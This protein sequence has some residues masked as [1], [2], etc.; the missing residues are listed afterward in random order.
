MLGLIVLS[1]CENENPIYD[2][3]GGIALVGFEVPSN[4]SPAPVLEDSE[5][6]E[7]PVAVSVSNLSPVDRTYDITVN[8][9]DT[10]V[11][12]ENYTVPMTVT[13]PANQYTTNLIVEID[14]I[15]LTPDTQQIVLELA[16]RDE[17]NVLNGDIYTLS[18]FRSCPIPADYAVGDYVLEDLG[19]IGPA[20]G[21]VNITE[22]TYTLEVG[23]NQAQRVFSAQLLPLFNGPTREIAVEF[24]CGNVL[25]L[26]GVVDSG[27]T[28]GDYTPIQNTGIT[29][30]LADD[31]S[32]LV[33]YD[34]RGNG[35][36]TA[37]FRLTKI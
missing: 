31:S 19:V 24:G 27:F 33:I 29:Y 21:T 3:S 7:F 6:V 11:P 12:S 8:D 1:S 17:S 30:D 18:I 37:A 9:V 34:E 5:D 22:G 28:F 15:S 26:G 14:D 4:G 20:N 13:I 10:T 35:A 2:G 23:S 36:V 32:F 25:K 16:T